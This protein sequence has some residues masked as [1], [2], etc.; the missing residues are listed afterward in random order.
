MYLPKRRFRK[1][2]EVLWGSEAKP[3]SLG[4]SEL[5]IYVAISFLTNQNTSFKTVFCVCV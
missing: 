2:R 3:D 5:K 4:D 1:H